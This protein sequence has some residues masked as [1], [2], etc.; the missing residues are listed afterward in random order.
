MTYTKGNTIEPNP[1]CTNRNPNA[2]P[3]AGMWTSA[4]SIWDMIIATMMAAFLPIDLYKYATVITNGTN[5]ISSSPNIWINARI[6]NINGEPFTAL[7]V[8]RGIPSA[9]PIKL[10][11][12][13][14]IIMSIKPIITIIMSLGLGILTIFD[15]S[16]LNTYTTANSDGT[17]KSIALSNPLLGGIKYGIAAAIKK[18][19]NKII[20][21]FVVNL[22]SPFS[23]G[24]SY[25]LSSNL[26]KS[27]AIF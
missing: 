16:S 15:M 18:P 13:P 23:N 19:I 24:Q 14:N 8:W 20:T 3:Y 6:I 12:C 22:E 5:L 9:A 26:K 1:I 25:S 7:S 4:K 17:V 2:N 10:D 27:F 21:F 11:R